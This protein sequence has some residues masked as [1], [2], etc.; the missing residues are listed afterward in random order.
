MTSPIQYDDRVWQISIKSDSCSFTFEDGIAESC[1]LLYYKNEKN[2][3]C[4]LE[5]CPK[6]V[7]EKSITFDEVGDIVDQ[8]VEI[9]RKNE[10]KI[11]LESF[12]NQIVSSRFELDGEMVVKISDVRVIL[13][14]ELKGV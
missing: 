7:E 8:S 14:S 3:L 4:T 10:R 6:R 5:N 2:Q 11:S 9:A 13:E 12:M 1:R